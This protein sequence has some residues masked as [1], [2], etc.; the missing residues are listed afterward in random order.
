MMKLPGVMLVALM[1]YAGL[2]DQ[3][4][5]NPTLVLRPTTRF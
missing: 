4:R 1:V 2:R 5:Q 3:G